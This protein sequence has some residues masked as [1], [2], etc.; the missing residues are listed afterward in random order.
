VTDASPLSDQQ[1]PRTGKPFRNTLKRE[2]RTTRYNA[3]EKTLCGRLEAAE[4]SFLNPAGDG[5]NHQGTP[6]RGDGSAPNRTFHLCLRV[7]ASSA[8]RF[9]T[10]GAKSSEPQSTVLFWLDLGNLFASWKPPFGVHVRSALSISISSANNV[11]HNS[12]DVNQLG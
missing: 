12:K 4:R 3:I 7:A 1:G 9:T 8:G 10:S 2:F 5:A 11:G 6:K